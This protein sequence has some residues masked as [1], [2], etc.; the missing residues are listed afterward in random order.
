MKWYIIR[1]KN[2]LTGEVK[3]I[4]KELANM[5]EAFKEVS[6]IKKQIALPVQR[7][8]LDRFESK[9]TYIKNTKNE[10]KVHEAQAS[11]YDQRKV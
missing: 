8:K 5:P 1:V 9:I 11:W 7:K 4:A 3:E 2:L 10:R 6:K